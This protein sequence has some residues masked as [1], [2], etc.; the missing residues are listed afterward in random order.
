MAFDYEGAIK[1]G[2]TDAD[3]AG[4]LASK[5]GFN[6]DGAL[7]EGYSHGDIVQHL[8]K[9]NGKKEA[10]VVPDINYL[11]LPTIDAEPEKLDTT[12]VFSTPYSSVITAIRPCRNHPLKS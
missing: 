4:H 10:S 1:E 9:G 3:I 6:L 2:Y 8:I 12:G 7:K 5:S 11:G